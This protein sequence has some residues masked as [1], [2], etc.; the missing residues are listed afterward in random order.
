M[1]ISK[2]FTYHELRPTD[3]KKTTKNDTKKELGVLP[4]SRRAQFA[5]PQAGR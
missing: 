4:G 2:W 5:S 3:T 1:R